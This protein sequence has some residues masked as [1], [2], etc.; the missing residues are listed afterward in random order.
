MEA[1]LAEYR[2][3][4]RKENAKS[5]PIHQKLMGFFSSTVCF[6][7]F[8]LVASFETLF[9]I[10]FVTVLSQLFFLILYFFLFPLLMLD[11]I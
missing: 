9:P 10:V 8:F 2:A 1:K 11:L 6:D 7:I 5:I 3:R 4:K